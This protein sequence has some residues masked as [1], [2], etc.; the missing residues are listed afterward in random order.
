MSDIS[1][2][3]TSGKLNPLWYRGHFESGGQFWISKVVSWHRVADDGARRKKKRFI[4]IT[5]PNVA[6]QRSRWGFF[7]IQ[8]LKHHNCQLPS[9]AHQAGAPAFFFAAKCTRRPLSEVTAAAAAWPHKKRE[10]ISTTLD[11]PK[12][13]LRS[14]RKQEQTLFNDL[15]RRIK[16]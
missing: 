4:I 9:E 15:R 6:I 16:K 10:G 7:S 8:K 13:V 3:F 12:D 1:I 2:Y 14:A 11:F 5:F